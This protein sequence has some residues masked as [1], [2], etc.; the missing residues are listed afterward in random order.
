MQALMRRLAERERRKDYRFGVLAAAI[1]NAN[2]GF[3]H[4]PAHASDFFPSIQKPTEKKQTVQ[5]QRAEM[6]KLQQIMG[7]A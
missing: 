5:E 2:G 6:F 1:Y 3:K 7:E 4:R